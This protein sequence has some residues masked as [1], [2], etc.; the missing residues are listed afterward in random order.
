MDLFETIKGYLGNSGAT[1]AEGEAAPGAAAGVP[2]A[3]ITAVLS[4]LKEHGLSNIIGMLKSKGLGNLVQS[5][6]GSGPNDPVSGEQLASAFDPR[7]VE[8]LSK[9]SGVP[10]SQVPSMLAQILPGLIDKLTPNGMLEEGSTLDQALD[11][12]KARLGMPS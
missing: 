7:Q 12:V 10:A 8:K 3:L 5:W 1:P 11:F 2:A 6:I 4:M 9:E